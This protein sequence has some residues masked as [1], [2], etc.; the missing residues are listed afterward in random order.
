MNLVIRKS[1]RKISIASVNALTRRVTEPA[2]VG[3]NKHIHIKITAACL[4]KEKLVFIH[5]LI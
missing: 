1:L 4:E 3:F 2:A 5:L